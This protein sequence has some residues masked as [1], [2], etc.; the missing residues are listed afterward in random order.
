MNDY[1]RED[2]ILVIV[3][4]FAAFCVGKFIMMFLLVMLQFYKRLKYNIL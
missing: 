2:V 4:V 3:G 1:D